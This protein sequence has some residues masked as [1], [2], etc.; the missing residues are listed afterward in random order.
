[1]AAKPPSATS[2][3]GAHWAPPIRPDGSW[4]E[5]TLNPHQREGVAWLLE[6]PNAVLADDVGLG[7][8]VEALALIGKLEEAGRLRRRTPRSV[9]RVLWITDAPLL[10]QTKAEVRQFLPDFTVATNLDPEFRGTQKARKEWEQLYGA[11]PD[12]LVL[13]Y[14]MATSRRHWLSHTTPALLVL[15]EAMKIKGAGARFDAVHDVASRSDR[16]LSM[17]ATPLENNPMELYW[18]LKATGV[19]NL[20]PEALFKQD[21]VTWRTVELGYGRSEQRPVGWRAERLDEVRRMLTD[22]LIQRSAED[23][24]LSL[25]TRVGETHRL[26][27]IS[28]EQQKAYDAAAKKMGR[29]A[30]VRM[31]QAAKAAGAESRLVDELMVELRAMGDEQAIVYC[32]YLWV[33]DLV[34][35][36]LIN[37]GIAYARIEGKIKDADRALAV[38][39]FRS[40]DARVLL[41]SRVLERGLNLQHCRRLVSLD[42]SWNPA[43]ERQRE[44]RIRRIGS[45]HETFQHLTLLPDTPLTRGKLLQLA[46]KAA[47]ATAVS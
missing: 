2:S 28:P 34:E 22:V 47:T 13:S 29:A 40:G 37:Q 32:E 44:G 27:A 41:G 15:D 33:L 4:F 12:I 39:A 6:R 43:R 21:F 24:G 46:A 17:T 38:E 23:V 25:P 9:C 11:G 18:L 20:W 30:V 16:V 19:P 7:K 10:E 36:R 1:M 35:E 31:E 3:P 14:E 45:A 8:T 42:A 26:V 5:G